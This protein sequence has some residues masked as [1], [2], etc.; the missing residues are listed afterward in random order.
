MKR[1]IKNGFS[2]IE[3]LVTLFF[4]AALFSVYSFYLRSSNLLIKKAENKFEDR[5]KIENIASILI[6]EIKKDLTPEADSRTDKIWDW[7]GTE[8]DGC[9]ISLRS[10]SGLL[11]LN[12]LP[13]K[14]YL[15]D[16]AGQ[17]F[18]T[19]DYIQYIH[20]ERSSGNLFFSYSD[21]QSIISRKNF[22]TFLQLIHLLILILLMKNP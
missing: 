4:L 9:K 2:S 6:E 10:L 3:V 19:P 15:S 17:L 16:F 7:N 13:E 21:L 8:Y 12:F 18:S 1:I 11:D 22:D 5:K 14:I 20:D